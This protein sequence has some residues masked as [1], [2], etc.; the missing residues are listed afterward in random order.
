MYVLESLIDGDFYKGSSENYLKRLQE[1]NRG[2]S[3]FIR[4]KGPWKLIFAQAFETKRAALIQ[5]K[6]LKKCNK[7]YLQWLMT[8]PCNILNKTKK[9]K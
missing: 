9:F 3:K 6:K 5:E 8:E 1:H 4:T 2:E 7:E